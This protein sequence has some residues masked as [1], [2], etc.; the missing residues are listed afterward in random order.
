MFYGAR[1]Q[2]MKVARFYG[3]QCI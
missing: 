1:P 3:L 2:K